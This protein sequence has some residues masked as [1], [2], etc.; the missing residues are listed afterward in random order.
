MKS[1][2]LSAGIMQQL[3]NNGNKNFVIYFFLDIFIE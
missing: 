3:Y 2:I 1:M